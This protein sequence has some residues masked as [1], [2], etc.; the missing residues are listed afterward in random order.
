MPYNLDTISAAI[1]TALDTILSPIVVTLG[2]IPDPTELPV[3]TDGWFTPYCVYQIGDT[4]QQGATSF[5][6]P[7]GDSYA[8][9]IYVQ[10]IAPN[11]DSAGKIRNKLVTQF[12]GYNFTWSGPVRKSTAGAVFPMRRT[13]G[14]KASIMPCSFIIPGVQLI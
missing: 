6:G 8:L 11:D 14:T 9:P 4:R 10:V 12:T 7:I 13:D 5:V 1:D 3:A 2:S